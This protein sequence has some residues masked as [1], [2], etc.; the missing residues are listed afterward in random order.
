MSTIIEVRY[1]KRIGLPG[2]SAHEYAVTLRAEVSDVALAD[3]ESARLYRI[4]QDAVDRELQT[5]GYVPADEQAGEIRGVNGHT[6]EPTDAGANGWLCSGRQRELILTIA[7]ER[8]MRL[9][10]VELLAQERFGKELRQLT[11]R[12]ASNIISRLMTA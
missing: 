7:E 12:Q 2:Y 6:A 9:A 3:T 8:Q 1:A 5:P 10:E 4:L 11:R